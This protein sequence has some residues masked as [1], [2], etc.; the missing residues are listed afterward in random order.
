M[1]DKKQN[2]EDFLK[3]WN[4][5]FNNLSYYRQAVTHGSYFGLKKNKTK[6]TESE[7]VGNYQDLEFLGD[8]ILQ[9][10]STDFVFRKFP[11]L[12]AGKMT[13]IRSKLVRTKTL[14]DL[15]IKIGLKKFLLTAPG[16]MSE[17]A[18]QSIKVGAD[19]FEAFIAA[20]YLDTN[21]RV[22]KEFLDKTV[23]DI[24][25]EAFDI[26][27]LK[28]AK[29]TFQEQI[30][31]F[32]KLAVVYVVNEKGLNEFEAQAIHDNKIYGFGIGKSKVEAEENAALD[33]LHKMKK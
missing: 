16:Q 4:I 14:N 8:A 28:D 11:N 27:H 29:T 10:F 18:K 1:Q 33:A 3:S 17:D 32:S 5:N 9:Y 23:F 22:V 25:I 2:I 31:S 30:Q 12:S 24:N 6:K 20:I 7:R 26:E 19:I 21:L 15:S 13:L